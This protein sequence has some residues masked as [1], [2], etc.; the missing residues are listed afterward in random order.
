MQHE[1]LRWMPTFKVGIQLQLRCRASPR[2]RYVLSIGGSMINSPE[3]R[4]CQ[5]FAIS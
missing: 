1:F 5:R 2:V 3:R 4:G